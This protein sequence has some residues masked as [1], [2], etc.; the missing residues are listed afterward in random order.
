MFMPVHAGRPAAVALATLF[1]AP[2]FRLVSCCLLGCLLVLAAT[3]A[4]QASTSTTT[5][6]FTILPAIEVLAWPA[7]TL[8]LSGSPENH[9]VVGPLEFL[10]R[11]NAPWSLSLHS[12]VINGRMREYDPASGV[13]VPS[14][15][16]LAQALEW[17]LS[18]NGPWSPV[19]DSSTRVVTGMPPTDSEGMVVRLY[20]RQSTSFDDVMLPPGREY[21]MVLTYTAALS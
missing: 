16:V 20:L 11:A 1:S 21:R 6:S 3:G 5:V 17:G 7:P 19:T 4:S 14:G 12:D 13:Y 10:V 18:P 2:V 9:A 8:S 15:H